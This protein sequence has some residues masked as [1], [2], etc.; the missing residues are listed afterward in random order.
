M[1]TIQFHPSGTADSHPKS[2]LEQNIVYPCSVDMCKDNNP[3]EKNCGGAHAQMSTAYVGGAQLN[4]V[5]HGKGMLRFTTT[6]LLFVI[7]LIVSLDT[8]GAE[9]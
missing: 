6:S 3:G 5:A 4:P 7:S 2:Y 8:T 9:G 1:D